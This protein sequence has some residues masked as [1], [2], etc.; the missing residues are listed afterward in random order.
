MLQRI[1]EPIVTLKGS[2]KLSKDDQCFWTRASIWFS[3]SFSTTNCGWFVTHIYVRELCHRL[4]WIMGSPIF[5]SFENHSTTWNWCWYPSWLL[6]IG[7]AW[8]HFIHIRL[9]R[10]PWSP[11][12]ILT[13]GSIWL[14]KW[15]WLKFTRCQLK[16]T[17]MRKYLHRAKYNA[18][19]AHIVQYKALLSLKA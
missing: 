6:F 4:V 19:F 17:E 13:K 10:C 15:N 14:F 7:N 12:F 18:T 11:S 5:G 8:L 3:T 16:S 9:R 1:F 2:L